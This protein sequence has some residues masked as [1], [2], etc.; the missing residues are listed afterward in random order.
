MKL[1]S[2]FLVEIKLFG[3]NSWIV[4]FGNCIHVIF[5]DVSRALLKFDPF[6]KKHITQF[7]LK[8][9]GLLKNNYELSMCAR[10]TVQTS[11]RMGRLFVSLGSCF[12]PLS[13]PNARVCLRGG[14]KFFTGKHQTGFT[15]FTL[16][17]FSEVIYHV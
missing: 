8:F 2:S 17:P 6:N 3:S 10:K 15:G 1:F 16:K 4:F 11:L 9:S 5:Q 12:S 14:P 7:M 13:M